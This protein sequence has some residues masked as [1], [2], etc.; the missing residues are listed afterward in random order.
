MLIVSFVYHRTVTVESDGIPVLEIAP[1]RATTQVSQGVDGLARQVVS[2]ALRGADR[3]VDHVGGS[4][5]MQF[6]ILTGALGSWI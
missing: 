6:A 5:N 3:D 2:D 1:R 4:A